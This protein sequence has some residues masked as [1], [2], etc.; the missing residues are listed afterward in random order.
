M[1][2]TSLK[3]IWEMFFYFFRISW[4][5]FGGGWSIVAQMQKDFVDDKKELTAEELLD[6]VS[7]GRSAMWPICSDTVR[8]VSWAA[9]LQPSVW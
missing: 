5:T 1:K 8:P 9:L 7:V 6:I 4:F 3:K 2:K